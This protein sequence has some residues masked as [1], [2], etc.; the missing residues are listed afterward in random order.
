MF[1]QLSIFHIKVVAKDLKVCSS[2]GFNRVVLANKSKRFAL[3]LSKYAQAINFYFINENALIEF[4][5]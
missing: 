4:S 3:L 1:S 2:L 5:I